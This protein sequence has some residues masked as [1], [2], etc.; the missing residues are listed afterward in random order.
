[1]IYYNSSEG[2]LQPLAL[3][4]LLFF[5]LSILGMMSVLIENV[6]KCLADKPVEPVCR[7]VHH[8]H[9]GLPHGPTEHHLFCLK[10]DEAGG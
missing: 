2:R 9:T 1:M 5:R 10:R 7:S 8:T 3:A 4:V 6:R